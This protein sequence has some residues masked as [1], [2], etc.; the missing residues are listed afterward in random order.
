MAV[1]PGFLDYVLGQLC[2]LDGVTPRRGMEPFRPFAGKPEVSMSYFELPPEVLEDAE[3]CGDWARKS[4]AVAGAATQRR[5]VAAAG[6]R[7]ARP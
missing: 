7:K 3:Q 4:V 2:R 1:T 6:R 5:R